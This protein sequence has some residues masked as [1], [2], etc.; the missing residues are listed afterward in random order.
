MLHSRALSPP[1]GTALPRR[2]IV[3]GHS[4]GGHF[5]SVVG[6]RLANLGHPNL[7]GA[8]L[9]DAVAADGFSSN[10]QAI[11]A[12]KKL[13][14]LFGNWARDM[15]TGTTTSAYHCTERSN[16]RTCGTKVK[17][18]VTGSLPRSALIR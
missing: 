17:E 4:A 11:S 3:G 12:G 16:T 14:E 13:R 7:R 15:G 1:Q 5:A 10:L 18:L 2:Y 9:A 8:I 6:A